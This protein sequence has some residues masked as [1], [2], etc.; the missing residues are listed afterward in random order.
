MIPSNASACDTVRKQV[1]RMLD[2]WSA[3]QLLHQGSSGLLS[4][5]ESVTSAP[6]TN[7][8]PSLVL[9]DSDTPVSVVETTR[10]QVR[11]LVQAGSIPN[12]QQPAAVS[13]ALLEFFGKTKKA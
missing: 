6:L 3:W 10:T 13:N 8:I 11:L 7:A 12:L 4:A 1:W 5:F 2:Q 9:R